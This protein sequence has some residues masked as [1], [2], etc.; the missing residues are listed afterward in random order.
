MDRLTGSKSKLESLR[1]SLTSVLRVFRGFFGGCFARNLL[2]K[3]L[4]KYG[5][6]PEIIIFNENPD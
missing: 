4:M 1:E 6:W 5:L 2:W 3:S